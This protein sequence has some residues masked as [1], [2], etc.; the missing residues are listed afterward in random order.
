MHAPRAYKVGMDLNAL[1][2]KIRARRKRARLSQRTLAEEAGLSISQVSRIEGGHRE[3]PLH[4]FIRICG[5]LRCRP[6]AILDGFDP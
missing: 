4:T 5:A 2:N 6:G 3:P 1:G